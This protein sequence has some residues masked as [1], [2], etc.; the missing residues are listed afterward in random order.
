MTALKCRGRQHR[1]DGRAWE[2]I[3]EAERDGP[4]RRGGGE[5]GTRRKP[6]MKDEGGG[7]GREGAEA[8][9]RGKGG[10][11]QN[12]VP[13]RSRTKIPRTERARWKGDLVRCGENA[14]PHQTLPA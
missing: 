7:G 5:A 13:R 9:A 8:R 10:Q 1:T 11:T 3:D 4:R 14:E 12:L 6:G 2:V